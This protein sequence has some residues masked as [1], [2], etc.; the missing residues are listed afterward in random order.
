MKICAKVS[1]SGRGGEG[2]ATRR[3]PRDLYDISIG[4]L[5]I[6]LDNICLTLLF[7]ISRGA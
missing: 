3:L 1:L 2:T 6:R 5:R 4:L 7:E